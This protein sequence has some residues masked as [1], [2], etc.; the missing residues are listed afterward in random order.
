MLF[1]QIWVLQLRDRSR[2]GSLLRPH[3]PP[4]A[5]QALVPVAS[6]GRDHTYDGMPMAKVA[7]AAGASAE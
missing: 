2:A 7:D 4:K 6:G 5:A 3:V 1:L